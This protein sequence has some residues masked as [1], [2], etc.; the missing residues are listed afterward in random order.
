LEPILLRLSFDFH[1]GIYFIVFNF[2]KRKK[3]SNGADHYSTMSKHSG[4]SLS[5]KPHAFAGAVLTPKLARELTPWRVLSVTAA[6]AEASISNNATPSSSHGNA[7]FGSSSGGLS[8]SGSFG[9][10]GGNQSPVTNTFEQKRDRKGYI[11]NHNQAFRRRGSGSGFIEHSSSMGSMSMDEYNYS[12]GQRGGEPTVQYTVWITEAWN[13]L[14]WA[15]PNAALFWEMATMFHTLYVAD[16]DRRHYENNINEDSGNNLN[17]SGSKGGQDYIPPLLSCGSTSSVGTSN[18]NPGTVSPNASVASFSNNTTNLSINL[19]NSNMSASMKRKNSGVVAKELP[20]WLIGTFL[21]L[22]CEDQAFARNVSGEDERRFDA[23]SRKGASGEILQPLHSSNSIDFPTLLQHPSL[24]P[25]TRIHAGH[26]TDS[27]HSAFLLAHLRKFLLFLALPHNVD[28]LYAIKELVEAGDD[29]S[30]HASRNYNHSNPNPHHH[31]SHSNIHN[32]NLSYNPHSTYY[33]NTQ[34]INS[35]HNREHGTIGFNVNFTPEDL[36]R[37]S[38]ILQAPNGGLIDDPPLNMTD[39]FYDPQSNKPG[40]SMN[41][42][43]NT[44]PN[45]ERKLREY[46][47]KELTFLMNMSQ[48]DLNTDVDNEAVNV[49]SEDGVTSSLSKMSIR[50]D[51]KESHPMDE[52]EE[53]ATKMNNRKSAQKQTEG[54]QKELSYKNLSQKSILLKPRAYPD[55]DISNTSGVGQSPIAANASGSYH[56]CP[57]PSSL[58]TAISN[59]GRLHDLTIS[60]CNDVHMYL[61]QPFENVTISACTGCHIVIGAVAGLLHVVDCERTTITSASRRVLV[62]NSFEVL[63]CI[64]TPSPPLLVGDNRSCQF[65][66]YNTYY[67]GLKEDLLATGLAA[68]VVNSKQLLSENS[69]SSQHSQIQQ[70]QQY[71]SSPIQ[72]Q[73][74]SNKWKIPLEMAK[75]NTQSVDPSSGTSDKTT[76]SPKQQHS[77]DEAMPTPILQPASEFHIVFVPLE[78]ESSRQRRQLQEIQQP[79]FLQEESKTSTM[80]D[81]GDAGDADKESQYCRNLAEILQLSPFHLPY[82]YEKRVIIKAERIKSLQQAIRTDLSPEQQNLVQEELNL[83]FR[84]WLVTSGNL[85]QVLDLVHMENNGVL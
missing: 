61:L 57:S 65:A 70:V 85:R 7:F 83:G 46:L 22:H 34:Q 21:L 49:S 50:D 69:A 81:D 20:V 43:W 45:V 31:S 82:E 24:S 59:P 84:D 17:N 39:F 1:F 41:K 47:G 37:L 79:Q 18:T 12:T 42:N 2:S 10:N 55:L 26:D 62:S 19:T 33:P 5:T 76:T 66:P 54:Y 25:R 13:I 44:L 6:V 11:S 75:L 51:G 9:G 3:H 73:C 4:I 38:F 48:N 14:K 27:A 28:A 60:D 35:T 53:D 72:V 74:S 58:P 80:N 36:E 68:C 8:H 40:E 32:Q 63:N 23:V 71:Q 29:R 78:S 56:G 77:G 16:R 64:F 15:Q 67:E 30:S 52:D